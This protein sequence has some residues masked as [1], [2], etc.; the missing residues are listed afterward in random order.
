LK[1]NWLPSPSAYNVL[2][3]VRSDLPEKTIDD[4]RTHQLVMGTISPGMLPAILVAATNA[5]LG[6]HIKG[7][8]GHP[9]LASAML[10]MDRGEIDG[11]PAVPF[12]SME[13]VYSK[14][15]AAGKYRLMLQFGAAAS[16]EYPQAAFARDLA[17]T[18]EDRMLLDLAMDPLKVGYP[19]MLGPKVPKERVEAM[20]GAFMATFK[21]SKFLEEAKKLTLNV[22]PV[23]GAAIESLIKEAYAMPPKVIERMRALAK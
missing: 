2:M 12:Q 4:M 13:R 10:A 16:P 8:N 7:I 6:T 3:L 23:E 15:L 17:K 20:R 11:Y 5:T 14:Q 21:D 9:N 19:F 22:A 1:I 18:P